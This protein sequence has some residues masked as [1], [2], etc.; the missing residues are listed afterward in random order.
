MRRRRCWSGW[1]TTSRAVGCTPATTSA[2]AT[3]WTASLAR[4]PFRLLAVIDLV[5]RIGLVGRRQISDRADSLAAVEVAESVA[6]GDEGGIV[7]RQDAAENT[8]LDVL[9]RIDLCEALLDLGMSFA[10]AVEDRSYLVRATGNVILRFVGIDNGEA[11]VILP[12]MGLT[13]LVEV[14]RRLHDDSG[15]LQVEFVA[16]E[17]KEIQK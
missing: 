12:C 14:A 1:G 8:L 15:R 17:I 9:T 10:E 11:V 5:E 2:T 7:T 4:P 3:A 16:I 13:D 6:L